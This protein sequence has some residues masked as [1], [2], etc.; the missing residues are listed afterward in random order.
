[1]T[2]RGTLFFL[3]N[4]TT[5]RWQSVVK[6]YCLLPWKPGTERHFQNLNRRETNFACLQGLKHKMLIWVSGGKSSPAYLRI[7]E[8]ISRKSNKHNHCRLLTW[9]KK[10]PIRSPPFFFMLQFS[11]PYW[12]T[13]WITPVNYLYQYLWKSMLRSIFVRVLL[14]SA[15]MMSLMAWNWKHQELCALIEQNV[16]T[17]NLLW[18]S[19]ILDTLNVLYLFQRKLNCSLLYCPLVLLRLA[20]SNCTFSPLDSK[21]VAPVSYCKGTSA[22]INMPIIFFLLAFLLI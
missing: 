8:A 13:N 20:K 4:G 16:P 9:R 19:F 22:V 6:C 11:G 1:M 10:D 2:P 7:C 3:S 5:W 18:P 15:K 21:A 12:F 17:H 14:Q